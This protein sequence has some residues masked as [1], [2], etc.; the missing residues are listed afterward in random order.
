MDVHQTHTVHPHQPMGGVPPGHS[1]RWLAFRSSLPPQ[2]GGLQVQ[3]R[4]RAGTAARLPARLQSMN[5]AQ[6]T[7]DK[8]RLSSRERS[9]EGGSSPGGHVKKGQV[10]Y[11]G[12]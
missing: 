4:V 3:H 7:C 8:T 10:F 12:A 1:H 9:M 11:Y 6:W 2:D 5:V